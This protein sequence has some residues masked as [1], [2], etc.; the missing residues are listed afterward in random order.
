MHN[1]HT[2]KLNEIETI[3]LHCLTK[4]AVEKKYIKE[5]DIEQALEH[6]EFIHEDY[7]TVQESHSCWTQ[8]HNGHYMQS[9]VCEQYHISA[10]AQVPN[11]I[12]D[13]TIRS[14]GCVYICKETGRYHVCQPNKT[15]EYSSVDLTSS[16]FVCHI[17]H[18]EKEVFMPSIEAPTKSND[19]EE[20]FGN[21]KA[22]NNSMRDAE[23]F[24]PQ[25]DA[26]LFKTMPLSIDELLNQA[27]DISKKRNSE[28]GT[29]NSITHVNKPTPYKGPINMK[30]L[31]QKGRVFRR[32]TN[33]VRRIRKPSD[34]KQ[35]DLLKDMSKHKMTAEILMKY[36]TLFTNRHRYYTYTWKNMLHMANTKTISIMRKNSKK[37]PKSMDYIS[38][39]FNLISGNIGHRIIKY[40]D[41]ISYEK[42]TLQL[43]KLWHIV[44]TSP[45]AKQLNKLIHDVKKKQKKTFTLDFTKISFA[46]L[47]LMSQ[48]GSAL[49]CSIN[50]DIIR[51]YQLDTVYNVDFAH[52]P[53]DITEFF[54]GVIPYSKC[55]KRN[56]VG[57]DML[58]KYNQVIKSNFNL[59]GKLLGKSQ[60]I[61]V[62]CIDSS[63]KEEESKLL[64]K[65]A[66]ITTKH[67]NTPECA[68]LKHNAV[69]DYI[70]N[71]INKKLQI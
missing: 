17:S 48:G 14:S 8:I 68:I 31:L 30:K 16:R 58:D 37:K 67:I 25:K 56:I 2:D 12:L 3:R 4:L 50:N 38:V 29:H 27:I 1:S 18:D 45:K 5:Y 51:T 54:V 26:D 32:K 62:E 41:E 11:P 28:N 63:I 34:A 70:K 47:Y 40:N 46:A 10:G 64:D 21:T 22:Y 23:V 66:D 35:K 6:A 59:N 42:Y 71:C 65:L 39:L 44:A 57:C 52:A 69:T 19:G 60:K 33:I 20:Y 7:S 55:L 36:L 24:K 43:L 13:I 15:C 61:L 53:I 49:E 9:R